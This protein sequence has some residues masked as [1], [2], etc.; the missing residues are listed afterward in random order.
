MDSPLLN[1]PGPTPTQ[2]LADLKF[3]RDHPHEYL[4]R[5]AQEYGDVVQF[6]VPGNKAFFINHPDLIQHVLQ[7]NHH[8]YDKQTFQYNALAKITGQGLLTNSDSKDW[9]AKRRIS[10]P[11][12]S[13]KSL[14][15]I[16][17]IVVS[18][19]KAM[20]KTWEPYTGHGRSLD[21]DREMMKVSLDVVSKTLFGADLS[22]QA[23]LLTGAVMD[24]LDYLIY[25]TRTL[26]M[27]PGW[28]PI[29]QNYRFKQ[30]LHRIEAVVNTL[31]DQRSFDH[32]GDDFL[33]MLIGARDENGNPVLSRKEI[34]DE[35]VTL[36][37]AGHET[38][39]SSLTWS[40]YLLANNPGIC[41]K[42]RQEAVMV[43]GCDDPDYAGFEKLIYTQQVVNESLRL[44][45]PAWLITRRALGEDRLAGY[46]IP[47]NGLIIIS[48]Y[49]IHRH[50]GLWEDPD[51]FDPDRF[52]ELESNK[53]HRFSFIP[54]GGGPRLCIGNRFAMIEAVLILAII[55]KD[56]NLD[57]P[58]AESINVE[59]LV[60]MR[61]KGGLP[62][63]VRKPR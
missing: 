56:Y 43:S 55:T 10:Q 60:T 4:L 31:I 27:V 62:M 18:S 23:F 34:R 39:A 16:V 50:P 20:L 22:E 36:L 63:L 42:I 33:G 17:P 30:S 25:Q 29:K 61:P 21:I 2:L 1:L 51:V 58:A 9:L 13:K 48:P 52:A 49:T 45:P 8:N 40:W 6:A 57:L 46:L 47:K 35:V 14:Q 19:I 5:C 15:G 32:P 7:L 26:G 44:Y 28:L 41:K 59:A 53:H 37:I 12:F 54:F 11:A 3:I 24:A 38:V